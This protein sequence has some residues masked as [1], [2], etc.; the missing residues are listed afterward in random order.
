[1]D[2]CVCVCVCVCVLTSEGINVC[3]IS[4][5][6]GQHLLALRAGLP[7]LGAFLANDP[8]S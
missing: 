3:V 6:S 4:T 7:F 5:N 2:V 8:C 1:M